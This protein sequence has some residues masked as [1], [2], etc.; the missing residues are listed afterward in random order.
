MSPAADARSAEI[1]SKIKSVFGQKGFDGASMQ[2]LARAA[3]MSVGNFYRYF[4][5]KDA[6]VAALVQQDLSEVAG[7]FRHILASDD[8]RGTFLAA[9]RQEL[10]SHA[11][12]DE[13]PLWAEIEAASGRCPEICR[14]T[15]AMEDQVVRFLTQTI[16]LIV[17]TSEA[18][19]AARFETHARFIIVLYKA[20]AMQTRTSPELIDLAVE[21]VDRLLDDIVATSSP[22]RTGAVA[23]R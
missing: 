16:A 11:A 9:L 21:T 17:G 23:N 1:L 5:S 15:S 7:V 10:V 2:E 6:I 3:G 19:A 18:E 14:I 20:V 4:A 8:P 12:G 22:R 13:G